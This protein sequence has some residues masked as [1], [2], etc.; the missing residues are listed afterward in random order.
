MRSLIILFASGNVAQTGTSRNNY[1]C[2]VSRGGGENN[3]TAHCV[4]QA[5]T[6]GEN[7]RSAILG[8]PCCLTERNLR[9]KCSEYALMASLRFY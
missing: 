2:G 3:A 8:R 5:R 7:N 4:V 6:A 1:Y 9:Q